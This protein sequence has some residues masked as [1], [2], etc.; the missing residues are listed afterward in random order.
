MATGFKKQVQGSVKI[1]GQEA[2]RIT[3]QQAFKIAQ[4]GGQ[5]NDK[6]FVNLWA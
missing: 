4:E 1:T 2:F 5:R 3:G 6:L